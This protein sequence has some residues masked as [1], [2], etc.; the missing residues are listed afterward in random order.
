M[1]FLKNANPP[2]TPNPTNTDKQAIL[3]R[4]IRQLLENDSQKITPR[5]IQLVSVL[6][7]QHE[8]LS[9]SEEKAAGLNERFKQELIRLQEERR[10]LRELLDK[11]M[12]LVSQDG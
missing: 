12:Q 11:A 5:L 10:E 9:R 3:I 1:K 7:S 6:I 4:N 8:L 2:L